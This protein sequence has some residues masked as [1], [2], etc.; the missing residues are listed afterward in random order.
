MGLL[1]GMFFY[2][3]ISVTRRHKVVVWCF[4]LVALPLAILLFV[5]LIRNF[6]TDDPSASCPGCRY[7]SCFPTAANNYCKGTGLQTTT[8]TTTTTP[9]NNTI[10]F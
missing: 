3:I 4:R 9:T 5:V 6:Y 8:T 7:L 2:P 10:G 1:V